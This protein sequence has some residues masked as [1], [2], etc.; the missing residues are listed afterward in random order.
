MRTS[1]L[2][3]KICYKSLVIHFSQI[4]K[5]HHSILTN[6]HLLGQVL[7]QLLLNANDVAPKAKKIKISLSYEE[8]KLSIIIANKGLCMPSTPSQRAISSMATSKKFGIG[9]RIPF[10]FKVCLLWGEIYNLNKNQVVAINHPKL[11]VAS[12]QYQLH[13]L[14][15]APQAKTSP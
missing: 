1:P 10:A 4:L 11:A 8:V 3:Q 6:D 14:Q 5:F 7:Y 9:L 13:F 15:V 2:Q 12:L